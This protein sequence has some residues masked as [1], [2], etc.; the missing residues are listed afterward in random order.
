MKLILVLTLSVFCA[1]QVYAGENCESAVDAADSMNVNQKDCDY[2][3][4]GLNGV[5]HK[6]FKQ[7]SEGAVLETAAENSVG[8]KKKVMTAAATQAK[9]DPA[10][11]KSFLLSAEVNQWPDAALVRI[12]LL[13]KAMDKCTKGFSVEN[14]QYRPL[15]A[16]KIAMGIEFRCLE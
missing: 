3:D 12:Q 10:K 2:T 15:G 14:E 4:E 5:L 7:G 11:I 8:D 13:S 9:T 6:A 1:A 16:G